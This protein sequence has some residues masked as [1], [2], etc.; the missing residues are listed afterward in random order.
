VR[1]CKQITVLT[2]CWKLIHSVFQ[3]IPLF[4][5]EMYIGFASYILQV[6]SIYLARIL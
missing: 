6:I 5:P 1:I 2:L 4:I 3:I